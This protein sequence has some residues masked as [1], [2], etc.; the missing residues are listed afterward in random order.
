[1]SPSIRSLLTLVETRI[2]VSEGASMSHS[3]RREIPR[4]LFNEANL[5]KCYGK[6]YIEIEKLGVRDVE[7][8]HQGGPF[9]AAQD[10]SSGNLTLA[11]VHLMIR[12]EACP[13]SRPLN[14]RDAWPLYAT[15]GDGEEIDVFDG[16]GNLTPDM[17]SLLLGDTAQD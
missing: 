8:V 15:V 4:D 12:G 13:L 3:Y 11:N 17:R 2:D 10:S 6:L 7:L 1:M 9:M 5:L 16:S 14:S